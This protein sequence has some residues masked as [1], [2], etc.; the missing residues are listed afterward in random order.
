MS[1][2]S[3]DRPLWLS[4]ANTALFRRRV[5][6]DLD[7]ALQPIVD[8][9][10]GQL[11]ACESLVRGIDKLGFTRI[12]ELFTQAY[13]TD[14][15]F[16]LEMCLIEKAVAA[17][18]Q[19]RRQSRA[20]LFIN[21]DG[22]LA[23]EQVAVLE[24]IDRTI[25]AQGL[26]PSDICIELSERH[27]FLTTDRFAEEVSEFRKTGYSV[28]IDDFGTGD[29]GL[30]MLYQSNPNFL[31]I[32]RFFIR[33]IQSDS[34]KKLL[35]SAIVDLSHTMGVRVIAEGLETIQ[36]LYACRDIRCDLAQGFLIERPVLNPLKICAHYSIVSD[37]ENRRRPQNAPV[38]HLVAALETLGCDAS[39][40]E[41]FEKFRTRPTQSVIP[42]VDATG[43]PKGIVREQDIKPFIY[44]RFGRDLLQNKSIGMGLKDFLKPVATAEIDTQVVPLLDL[45]CD[46][47]HE[48]IL[49]TE[50]GKY[51][52]F[53]PPVAIACI[54]NEVRLEFAANCN[55]LTRLPANASIKSFIDRAVAER[56]VPRALCYVDLDNFKPFNDKYG[57]R[58]GDRALLLLAD[59]LKAM[60]GSGDVF[61][62]HVG[63]DDFFLGTIGGDT[64]AFLAAVA[65]AQ[66]RF[67]RDVESLYA[68]EDRLAGHL[69]AKDR[70]GDLQRFA[71]L[72][73]SA[74]ALILPPEAPPID[75]EQASNLLAL[76][77][78]QAKISKGSLQRHTLGAETAPPSSAK[79]VA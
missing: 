31:K 73:C 72:T 14:A 67:R 78:A 15:L 34:K 5:M 75:A 16:M 43:A 30:Q 49:V 64:R 26:E 27:Q 42:I 56:D 29:S 8:I 53:L 10:T 59:I 37:N 77:K 18:S 11:V 51:L 74:A 2:A 40:V 70:N 46:R 13:Q 38:R 52:G 28:A 23:G 41:V 79:L 60:Q 21:L 66:E 4:N 61:V 63:G 9:G 39:L 54:A 19:L 76:V 7:V 12:D 45:V 25:A 36:E 1:V 68:P 20:M 48:G 22:R 71:L 35:V 3:P 47:Q 55:P 44:S 17:F 24:G 33:S 58:T 62:G 6:A 65:Q 50:G 32:D 69:I 57:F